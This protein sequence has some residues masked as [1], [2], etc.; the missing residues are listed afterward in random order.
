MFCLTSI[1]LGRTDFNPL[2]RQN[3]WCLSSDILTDWSEKSSLEIALG[4]GRLICPVQLLICRAFCPME[5]FYPHKKK[6]G[7]KMCMSGS[8][9]CENNFFHLINQSRYVERLYIPALKTHTYS[10]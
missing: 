1:Q 10:I 7:D 6:S 9:S 5:D 3:V 8:D 2:V 4:I